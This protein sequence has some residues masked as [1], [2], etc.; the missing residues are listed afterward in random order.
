MR[1]V[2]IEKADGNYSA[3]VPD[4]PGCVAAGD[5]DDAVER[6]IREAIRFHIEGC[7][8]MVSRCRSQRALQNMWRPEDLRR[9]RRQL[10]RD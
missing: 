6:E 4:L 2:I 7:E 3:Y 10:K 5:T 1:Y 9:R 8:R